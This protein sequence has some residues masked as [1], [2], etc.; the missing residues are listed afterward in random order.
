MGIKTEKIGVGLWNG[1]GGGVE[2]GETIREAA[3]R[4]LREE[5][6]LSA[7]KE[8]LKYLGAVTFHN[9]RDDGSEFTVTVH[10]FF[11]YKWSGKLKAGRGM[12]NPSLKPIKNLPLDKM[13][14]ADK[15]WLPKTIVGIKI[16]DEYWYSPGQKRVIKS[17]QRRMAADDDVD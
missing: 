1:W 5:S 2:E 14:P 15:I 12:K 13:L 4:E 6:S 17:K 7:N 9:K 3:V 8:D 11:C 10:I 16:C